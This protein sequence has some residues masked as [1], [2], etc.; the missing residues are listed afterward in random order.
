MNWR[1]PVVNFIDGFRAAALER[2]LQSLRQSTATSSTRR[3]ENSTDRRKPRVSTLLTRSPTML[4]RSTNGARVRGECGSQAAISKF[5]CL[6][7]LKRRPP[8]GRD[9]R[10]CAKVALAVV[11]AYAFTLGE[12]NSYALYSVPGAAL[13]V[14][15]SVGEDLHASSAPRSVPWWAPPRPMRS[16]SRWGRWAP[17]SRSPRRQRPSALDRCCYF[18]AAAGGIPADAGV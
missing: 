5:P 8:R 18:P 10:Y 13:V 9:L 14:G 11:A 12:R 3:Q 15:G 16:A 6:Q 1:N 17:A 2:G 7:V 4:L